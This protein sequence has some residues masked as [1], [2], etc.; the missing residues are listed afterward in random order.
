MTKNQTRKTDL[1]RAINEV[2]QAGYRGIRHLESDPLLAGICKETT[3]TL[4]RLGK[5][6]QENQKKRLSEEKLKILGHEV[7]WV[8]SIVSEL[9]IS[10]IRYLFPRL[11]EPMQLPISGLGCR[12]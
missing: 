3:R 2:I 4:A 5:Q 12:K 11:W 9:C 8:V 7:A 6:L 1:E 10:L